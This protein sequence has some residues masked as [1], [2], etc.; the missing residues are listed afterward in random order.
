MTKLNKE[1]S[2]RGISPALS[3]QDSR[4][5]IR[6]V[7]PLPQHSQPVKEPKVMVPV[8]KK[9]AVLGTEQV[10]KDYDYGS[11]CPGAVAFLFAVVVVVG[12]TQ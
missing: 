7:S 10:C 2:D 12:V 11:D 8:A 9:S 1:I 3:S 6:L 4:G 5:F